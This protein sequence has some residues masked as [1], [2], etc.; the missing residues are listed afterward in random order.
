MKEFKSLKDTVETCNKLSQQYDDI[1]TLIEMGYEEE[2]PDMISEV[3]NELDAFISILEDV[4]N[5]TVQ[6]Q[7]DFLDSDEYI[8]N[9]ITKIVKNDSKQRYSV[10]KMTDDT[11]LVYDM[12]L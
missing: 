6:A 3:R 10:K 9:T 1:E 8:I 12:V 11:I 2:D 4:M 5:Q 7:L